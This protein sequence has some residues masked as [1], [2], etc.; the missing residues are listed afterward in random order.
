MGILSIRKVIKVGSALLVIQGIAEAHECDAILE[1]GVRNTYQELRTGDFRSSFSSA[2]CNKSSQSSGSTSGTAAGGSYGLYSFDFAQSGSD[3]S[4]SRNENCGNSSSSLQDDKYLRALQ[5]VADKNIVDAWSACRSSASGVLLNGE[6]NGKD[7]FLTYVFRSAGSVTQ[8]I[9]EGEPYIS[10]AK[11]SDAVKDG[12]V[13]NT[14]GRIQT[15]TRTGDGPVSI[16]INTNYQPA[17]FFIPAVVPPKPKPVEPINKQQALEE[18]CRNWKGPGVPTDC[19]GGNN[20][21]IASS[22]PGMGPAPQ[23]YRWCVLD[24]R[25]H[26]QPG[27]Q[28]YCFTTD[29]AGTCRCSAPPPGYPVNGKPDMYGR[30]FTGQ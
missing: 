14:G 22:P 16:A 24:S 15:C 17:R 9:V 13:I 19:P 10:G 18:K 1:Q 20:P 30:T 2:Y 12:T 27:V 7:I 21:S 29:G 4:A 26:P 6:L 25:F 11:C 23:G 3:N 8:A 5:S 28:S